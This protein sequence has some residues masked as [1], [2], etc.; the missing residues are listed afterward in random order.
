[1]AIR[2]LVVWMLFVAAPCLSRLAAQEAGSDESV[3]TKP[4]ETKPVEKPAEAATTTSG[5]LPGHSYHGEVFDDGPR[6]QAY[7]MPG[8]PKIKFPVTTKSPDAQRFI[9]QGIGQLHGFWYYEA[10]RSFGQAPMLDP[11][12]AMA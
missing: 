3:D 4:A 1:M 11:D 12:C 8:M 6:Q 10:E 2:T 7:L 5:P 9:E